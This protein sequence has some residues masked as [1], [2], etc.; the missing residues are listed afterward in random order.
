MK[1]VPR[2]GLV[3]ITVLMAFPAVA[4]E[5]AFDAGTRA[6][7]VQDYPSAL[8]HFEQARKQCRS[9]TGYA[10]AYADALFLMGRRDEAHQLYAATLRNEIKDSYDDT[11]GTSAFWKGLGVALVA[12]GAYV[13]HENAR[14]GIASNQMITTAEQVASI[15]TR[16]AVGDRDYRRAAKTAMADLKDLSRRP[17]SSIFVMNPAHNYIPGA[18]M[19]R[20]LL[21]GGNAC[22]AVRTYP[23]TYAVSGRCLLSHASDP[24]SV[25]MTIRI[26]AG[27]RPTEQASVSRAQPV[28]GSNPEKLWVLT[29][30]P[31]E[32]LVATGTFTAPIISQWTS[33][34]SLYSEYAITWFSPDLAHT[35]PQFMTCGSEGFE[36]CPEAG[37]LNA[38]RWVRVGD[39]WA[40]N[41]FATPDGR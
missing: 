26:G 32:S 33:D 15:D 20:V 40:T 14:A 29:V 23:A 19:A 35:S 36:G 10:R 37:S 9:C 1:A 11:K 8:E 7:E 25:P 41:G 4:G 38:L 24:M 5:S 12:A 18:A 31:D 13:D 6:M 27:L 28:D 21:S 22:N 39:R 34:E 2:L 30:Q 17:S 16:D 3:V